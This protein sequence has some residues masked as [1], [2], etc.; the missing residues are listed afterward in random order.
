[1]AD[2]H[3]IKKMKIGSLILVK[4]PDKNKKKITE[5]QKPQYFY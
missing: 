3:P 4:S 2:F 1:M 5:P